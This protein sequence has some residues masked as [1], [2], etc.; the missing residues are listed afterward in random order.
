MASCRI[1]SVRPAGDRQVLVLEC[2]NPCPGD[3]V[4]VLM[5]DGTVKP[6]LNELDTTGAQYQRARDEAMPSG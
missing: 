6:Y 2:V 1:G 3:E 5:S 4:R